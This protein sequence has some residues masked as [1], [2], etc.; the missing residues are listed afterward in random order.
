MVEAT[1]TPIVNR[2]E[3][4]IYLEYFSNIYWLHTDVFKWSSE[5][6]KKYLKE[7]DTLQ[8]LLN[9]DLYSLIEEE[10]TKLS[11]Y[12]KVIGFKYLRDLHGNDGNSYKIY[13][14][15]L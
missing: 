4:I 8:S 12:A 10:N 14:R 1:K 2:P 6:K 13:T 5:V 9:T 15:S 11:K 7:L 3:Y